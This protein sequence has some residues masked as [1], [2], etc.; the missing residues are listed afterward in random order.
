MKTWVVNQS[1]TERNEAISWASCLL[2]VGSKGIPFSSA[3]SK[4]Q[5]PDRMDRGSHQ[6]GCSRLL[7]RQIP[8]EVMD[9]SSFTQTTK[10]TAAHWA[11]IGDQGVPYIGAGVWLAVSLKSKWANHIS[12][13]GDSAQEK[14]DQ[15]GRLVSLTVTENLAL[16]LIFHFSPDVSC[17]EGTVNNVWILKTEADVVI[18]PSRSF[19]PWRRHIT[20]EWLQFKNI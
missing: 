19:L 12:V 6:D 15:R 2:G 17:Q 7:S 16:C 13:H 20:W 10:L 11:D 3:S 1:A 14:S 18:I 4:D 8:T 5:A 9:I